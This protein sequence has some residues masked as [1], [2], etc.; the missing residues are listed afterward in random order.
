MA[1]FT[2]ITTKLRTELY[3]RGISLDEVEGMKTGKASGPNVYPT[4]LF[5]QAGDTIRSAI[6]RLFSMSW[7][8][9][10]L[11]EMWKSADVKF[12]RKPGKSNYYSPISYRP[13]SLTSSLAKIME[14]ITFRLDAHIDGRS[15]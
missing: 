9:S 3:N 7:K 11:P 8:E 5:I 13:I 1:S 4:D 2:D 12:L 10:A 6:H 14:R 15:T